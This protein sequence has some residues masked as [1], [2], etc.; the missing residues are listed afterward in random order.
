MRLFLALSGYL[1]TIV[2]VCSECI[3]ALAQHER[4]K[5]REAGFYFAEIEKLISL[6]SPGFT[7]TFFAHDVGGL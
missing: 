1:I 5:I 4:L 7:F 2:G 6:V 3:L